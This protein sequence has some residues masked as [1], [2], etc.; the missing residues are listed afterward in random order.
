MRVTI[1]SPHITMSEKQEEFIIN[2]FSHLD[3]I[4]SRIEGCHV[5]FK[6]EKSSTQ[7]SWL[8]EA[9]LTVPGNDLFAS[10]AA[11]NLE[12]AVDRVCA[13]LESQLRKR[14][15]KLNEKDRKAK[16][17]ISESDFDQ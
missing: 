3:K 13:D 4:Y 12:L 15:E 5:I 16:A 8:I 7:N 10:E 9:K 2:K 6:R 1:Q 11:E 17:I 14:K